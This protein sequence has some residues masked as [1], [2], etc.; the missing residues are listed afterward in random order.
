MKRS[1]DCSLDLK[2]S[3]SP[4]IGALLPVAEPYYHFVIIKSLKG[5]CTPVMA[6]LNQR[7]RRLADMR[8]T[9][10]HYSIPRDRL[11]NR[12]PSIKSTFAKIIASP[13]SSIRPS[14][15]IQI[16][17]NVRYNNSIK[18][19]PPGFVTLIFSV[20][21]SWTCSTIPQNY[22]PSSSPS[23]FIISHHKNLYKIDDHWRRRFSGLADRRLTMA[24]RFNY[25][26][27]WVFNLTLNPLL[28][29]RRLPT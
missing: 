28:S 2:S 16:M 13:I 19:I 7:T 17:R 26:G 24:I 25:P 11:C 23:L 6:N 18:I 3:G 12:S 8:G 4:W 9:S 21:Q 22:C 29:T 1:F 5:P 27:L 15:C 10:V 14:L 20:P